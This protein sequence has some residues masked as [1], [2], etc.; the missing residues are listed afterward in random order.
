MEKEYLLYIF[1]NVIIFKIFV[2]ILKI[3]LYN[4]IYELNC[5]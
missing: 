5:E 4:L 3:A 1:E 2:L